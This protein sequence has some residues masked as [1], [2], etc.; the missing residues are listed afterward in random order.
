[1]KAWG[2]RGAIGVMMALLVVL[3]IDGFLFMGQMAVT[4]TSIAI[5]IAVPNRTKFI[6]FDDSILYEYD[7]GNYTLSTNT[8]TDELIGTDSSVNTETGD[9]FTDTFAKVKS[10]FT[11]AGQ[12]IAVFFQILAGP[13]RYLV[14]A[15]TPGWFSFTVGAIWYILTLALVVAFI[16]GRNTD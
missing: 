6:N 13:Y 1:M 11:S 14:M 5:G 9:I 10:W 4:D 12:G 15:G 3:S 7:R 2:K 16:A 8:S